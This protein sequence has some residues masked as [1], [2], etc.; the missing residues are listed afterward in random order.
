LGPSFSSIHLR[1]FSPCCS[2]R[3]GFV[4][5]R[6][7]FC[8]G[9]RC[10]PLSLI[11]LFRAYFFFSPPPQI[12]SLYFFL[13]NRSPFYFSDDPTC[14]APPPC[15]EDPFGAWL[16]SWPMSFPSLLR[17]RSVLPD[18]PV[19]SFSSPAVGWHTCFPLLL[20]PW[21]FLTIFFFLFGT[22]PVFRTR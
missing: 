15:S 22:P 11:C 4:W 6:G 16:Y 13:F 9:R 3:G 14:F 8:P 1:P 10:A 18:I 5:T 7:S 19:L 12:L 21:P 20:A 2:S 17:P